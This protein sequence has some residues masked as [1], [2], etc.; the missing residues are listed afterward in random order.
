MAQLK[1]LADEWQAQYESL[2]NRWREDPKSLDFEECI[3]LLGY[4][5][6]HTNYKLKANLLERLNGR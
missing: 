4:A 6:M 2:A 3:T 5:Q 1:E